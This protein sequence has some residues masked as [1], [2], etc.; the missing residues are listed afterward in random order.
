MVLQSV[1]QALK[2]YLQLHSDQNTATEI[3]D[4]RRHVICTNLKPAVITKG[5]YALDP[6]RRSGQ[7]NKKKIRDTQWQRGEFAEYN[8]HAARESRSLELSIIISVMM[9]LSGFTRLH[10]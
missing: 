6:I 3:K 9:C 10:V 5:V 1:Y 2:L 8:S 7:I 4:T